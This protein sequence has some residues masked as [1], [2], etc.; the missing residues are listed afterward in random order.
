MHSGVDAQTQ[1]DGEQR[2]LSV[3]RAAPTLALWEATP[4]LIV[5]VREMRAPRAIPAAAKMAAAG[6]P[7]VVRRSGGSAFPLAAGVL[8][9][10][11]ITQAPSN[12][13]VGYRQFCQ[14]IIRA[15]EPFGLPI[16]IGPTPGSFCDGRHNLMVDGQKIA[17]TSQQWRRL[18]GN[19]VRCLYHC[20]LLVDVAAPDL[21]D[22]VNCFYREAEAPADSAV[23]AAVIGAISDFSPT[24]T[25]NNTASLLRRVF[26]EITHNIP[27]ENLQ[28]Q[29]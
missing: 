28:R 9:I 10:S 3:P 8:N 21:V 17:G 22:A 5:G 19:Q 16:S 25:V 4:S 18:P 29:L 1:L 13:D 6:W 24:C 15:L 23:D 12:I 27:T 2:L 11:W 26:A 7:V 20:G 14:A